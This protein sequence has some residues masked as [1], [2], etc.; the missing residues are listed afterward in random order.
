MNQAFV[1]QLTPCTGGATSIGAEEA[2][3]EEGV[4]VLIVLLLL[5]FTTVETTATSSANASRHR[6]SISS[7]MKMTTPSARYVTNTML[8]ARGT[9]GIG[10]RKIVRKRRRSTSSPTHMASIQIGMQIQELP[11]ISQES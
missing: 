9:V 7:S 1:C 11:S 10:T 8:V 3:D 5:L 6:S 4:V 2:A